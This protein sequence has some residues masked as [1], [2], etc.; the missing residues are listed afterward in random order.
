MPCPRQDIDIACQ[1]DST[2]QI[3]SQPGV[4][5]LATNPLVLRENENCSWRRKC[6]AF[7]KGQETLLGA[8]S[9]L[10]VGAGARVVPLRK[11]P[12]W[13]RAFNPLCRSAYAQCITRGA[14]A[15]RLSR[16]CQVRVS[17]VA[18]ACVC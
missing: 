4:E 15:V 14:C 5:R 12:G 10:H 8:A 13:E 3:G 16:L 18:V 11:S 1:I 7:L 9:A 6:R 2:G 17:C